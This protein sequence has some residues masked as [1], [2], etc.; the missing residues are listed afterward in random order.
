ML[1]IRRSRLAVAAV[2]ALS[3]LGSACTKKVA[4]KPASQPVQTAKAAPATPP[5]AQQPASSTPAAPPAPARSKY[6]DA[7]TQARIDELIARIQDAY[8]DYDK[9]NIRTDAQSTLTSD[10][11]AL[12]DILRQYPDYKLT[13]EGHC[14][15]RGSDEYNLALGD[16][17]AKNAREFLSQLGIPAAQLNVVSYGKEK[18]QCTEHSEGCWQKNRRAHIVAMARAN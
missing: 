12:G 4:V 16:A 3:I 5:P 2:A 8:F 10:A 15:E 9:H 1:H 14:D 7:A 17:R 6:P 11:K 18:P 13:I